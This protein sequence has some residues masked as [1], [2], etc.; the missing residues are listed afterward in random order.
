MMLVVAFSPGIPAFT[1]PED[2]HQALAE[3]VAEDVAAPPSVA[4]G[5][6][7]SLQKLSDLY[8]SGAPS[9]NLTK[10]GLIF[11]GF[12]GTEKGWP[13]EEM[14]HPCTEGWC[15]GATDHWS[16]S[17]VSHQHKAVF[18]D[19]GIL[20]AP[21]LNTVM[22]SGIFDFGSLDAGCSTPVSDGI[23]YP[24]DKL[25]DMLERS[26]SEPA[27]EFAYNEVLIDTQQFVKNLPGS[28]GA[29][30]F[31][32]TGK[33]TQEDQMQATAAY[34][35]F[36]DTYKLTE[37]DVP[38]LQLHHTGPQALTDESAGARKYV[39][40]HPHAYQHG[41]EGSPQHRF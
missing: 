7:S 29:F 9:N 25:K 6:W 23:L 3:G 10:V 13:T 17:V 21:D 4:P 31:G 38:L 32:M 8:V 24:E 35:N 39:E 30:V 36:L 16:A 1:Q 41:C 11:H 2:S 19:A 14:W 5:A 22:C 37:A 34:V 12:D 40:D 28:V 18:S 33:G 26:F 27:L 15:Q 20:Y